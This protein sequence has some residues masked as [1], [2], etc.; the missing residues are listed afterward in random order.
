MSFSLVR[1]CTFV[2]SLFALLWPGLA[3][4]QQYHR[5]NLT[6]DK[7]TTAPAPNVDP[8]LVNDWG[9]ARG[10]GSPSWI[11]D[12][13]SGLSTLYNASGMPFVAPRG[14]Q[15][16]AVKIPTPDGTG[17]SA[18]TG[19]VFNASPGFLMAHAAYSR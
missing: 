17:T 6:V 11:S 2:A 14:T 10:N 4:A 8:N 18:P 16:V 12:N 13:G 19:T 7:S 5:T 15:P 9:I 3:G 1:R